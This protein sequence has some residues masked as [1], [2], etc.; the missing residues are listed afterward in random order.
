[1]TEDTQPATTTTD[2]SEPEATDTADEGE[3][4]H[5]AEAD[6]DVDHEEPDPDEEE[7]PDDADG[8]D[9]GEHEGEEQ[10]EMPTETEP[11]VVT[12]TAPAEPED[13]SEE[14]IEA[15]R[16]LQFELQ[17]KEAESQ[18]S[19]GQMKM[20]Y[21]LDMVKKSTERHAS[22]P[23]K[24]GKKFFMPMMFAEDIFFDPFE[25]DGHDQKG[26]EA[27]TME[28][29]DSVQVLEPGAAPSPAKD[30]FDDVNSRM[31]AFRKEEERKRKA[32]F[33]TT[34]QE[35]PSKDWIRVFRTYTVDWDAFFASQDAMVEL[36][37]AVKESER[38]YE[39]HFRNNDPLKRITDTLSVG[40]NSPALSRAGSHLTLGSSVSL[41]GTLDESTAVVTTLPYG[42][43]LEHQK[44]QQGDYKY[45]KIEQHKQT[46]LLTVEIQCSFGLV[47]L[48]L[49]FQKLPSMSMHDR[50]VAC[51]KENKGLVRLAFRPHKS[52]TFFIAVRSHET[53]AKFNI[54]TYSSSGNS[55]QSPII[56]RVNTIIR[57]FELLAAVDENELQEFY[58][59]YEKQALQ[60]IKEEEEAKRLQ[61]EAS[62][63]APPREEAFEPD[64]DAS[65]DELY[66][67]ESVGRFI[68]KVSKYTLMG[69]EESSQVY[70]EQGLQTGFDDDELDA[71]EFGQELSDRFMPMQSEIAADLLD[72]ADAGA[73]PGAQNGGFLPPIGRAQSL[74]S[75]EHVRS[76]ITMDSFGFED[77]QNSFKL[78]GIK[79]ATPAGTAATP[80]SY[81]TKR[82]VS[83][84]KSAISV[85]REYAALDRALHSALRGKEHKKKSVENPM[86]HQYPKPIKY[87]LTG[88]N[89]L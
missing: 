36:T 46:A 6:A 7:E 88:K 49:A 69:G 34:L 87:Q 52:G 70:G 62:L 67:I 13:M 65:I 86:L 20:K 12:N 85:A 9:E 31:A 43:I 71:Q 64:D 3:V 14:E 40:P 29:G 41:S 25:T 66:D 76:E 53:D 51:T 84:S 18:R 38:E 24:Q 60:T 2:T 55:D 59:K 5:D 63:H 57:K 73:D 28:D 1:M 56:A 79:G 27:A 39:L 37:A 77:E 23:R 78:P 21:F 30:P 22:H 8:D 72:Q 16:N 26:D 68:A 17:E 15:A 74:P 89:N 44:V 47:D 33:S 48:Y 50:H 45:Y 11:V 58:P 83:K 42:K 81:S 32:L 35:I 10:E 54:W 4:D 75:L 19:A 80:S 82:T 61:D